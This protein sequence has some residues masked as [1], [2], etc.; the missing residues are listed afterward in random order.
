MESIPR[1]LGI[2]PR[3]VENLCGLRVKF[4]VIRRKSFDLAKMKVSKK[5]VRLHLLLNQIR[6]R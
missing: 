1:H 6:L 2:D 4:L 5:L 3:D